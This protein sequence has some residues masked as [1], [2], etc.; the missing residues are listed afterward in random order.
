MMSDPGTSPDSAAA[1]R[2]MA[3]LVRR[4]AIALVGL[5]LVVTALTLF[6]DARELDD[7][8]GAFDWRFA[9][10]VLLLA[11]W[12]DGWRFL[13][14]QFFLREIGVTGL[15]RWLSLRIFLA[16]FAMVVTPGKLGEFIKAIYVRRHDGTP[17]NRTMAVVLAE[18][19][20]DALALLILAVIGSVAYAYGR[21]FVALMVAG[22][23]I[24]VA[25]LRHPA[26]IDRVLSIA[27]SRPMFARFRA[28][29]TSFFA[30]AAH[31]FGLR[32]LSLALALSVLSWFGECLALYLIL[33][34]LGVDG[35]LELLLA[36]TFILAVSSLAGGASMLP[37]G[38]GV[39]DAS[40]TGMLLLLVNDDAM[41]RGVAVAATLLIRFA[42]LWFAVLIGIVALASLERDHRTRARRVGPGLH[43]EA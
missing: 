36:S 28:E 10:P 24:A 19:A 3:E 11:L 27:G 32:R 5:V 25:L 4:G 41:S 33:V 21:V 6:A 7:A 2:G 42:T 31:L 13:K 8:I 18:R 40:M 17:A 9:V 1:P 16:G 23:L 29:I 39:A 22:G 43:G 20:T 15:P 37:G 30:T 35:S 38:L 12:N 26:T 34:G 14:W